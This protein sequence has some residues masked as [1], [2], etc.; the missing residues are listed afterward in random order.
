MEFVCLRGR[1][2]NTTFPLITLSVFDPLF[3]CNLQQCIPHLFLLDFGHPQGIMTHLRVTPSPVRPCPLARPPRP[4]PRHRQKK[5]W[6]IH[7]CFSKFISTL[8]YKHSQLPSSSAQSYRLN[9]SASS[10]TQEFPLRFR[11]S[12]R[13][14]E[15]PS[16]S[17]FS[18]KW[19]ARL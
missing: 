18:Q 7:S 10:F 9:L 16:S 19:K 17:I 4:R 3:A 13:R 12:F 8:T 15:F 14:Q 11:G 1:A 6:Q 5:S 2:I